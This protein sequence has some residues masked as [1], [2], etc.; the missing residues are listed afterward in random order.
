MAGYIFYDEFGYIERPDDDDTHCCNMAA[1]WSR[2]CQQTPPHRPEP[3]KEPPPEPEKMEVRPS[4]P[5]VYVKAFTEKEK[6]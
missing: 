6:K 4:V 3:P 5:A 1:W 2:M